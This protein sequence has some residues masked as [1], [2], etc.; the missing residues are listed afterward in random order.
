MSAS[1][2]RGHLFGIFYYRTPEAQG[3]R[4]EKMLDDAM[5]TAEKIARKK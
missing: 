1:R 3:R 2:R 5:A 4:I